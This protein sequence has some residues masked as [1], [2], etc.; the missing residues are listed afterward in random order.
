MSL[1]Y[2]LEQY[3]HIIRKESDQNL[4]HENFLFNRNTKPFHNIKHID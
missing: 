2:I 3:N 4:V 1:T